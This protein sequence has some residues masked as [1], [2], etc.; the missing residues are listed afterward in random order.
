MTGLT[1]RGLLAGALAG[2]AMPAFGEAVTHSLRPHGRAAATPVV[3]VAGQADDLVAKASLGGVTGYIVADVATGRVLEQVNADAPVP[4]A[5][6]AKTIT[7]L[8][9]LDRLGPQHRFVTRILAVG[10]QSGGQS[11]RVINKDMQGGISSRETLGVR[12]VPFTR[13]KE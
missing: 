6:V 10:T 13:E 12:F 3:A 1:R 4:P 7:A 2:A 11:L 8:Y 9:G 5:S